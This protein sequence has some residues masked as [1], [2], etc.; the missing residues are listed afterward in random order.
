[1][2]KFILLV[3]FFAS[4]SYAIDCKYSE[5]TALQVQS[6]NVLIQVKSGDSYPWKNLGGYDS[7]ALQSF[8][9]I[10]QQAIA[11]GNEVMLRFSENIVCSATDY[12]TVPIAFRLYKE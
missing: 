3:L 12:G 1:M 9:A 10:A 7:L 2:Y 11:T 4:N 5:V 6:G 8:Q